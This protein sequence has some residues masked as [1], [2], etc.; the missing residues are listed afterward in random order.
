MSP[1]DRQ[2]IETS[3]LLEGAPRRIGTLLAERAAVDVL[4]PGA[5]LF[6][7]GEPPRALHLIL[8]GRMALIAQGAGEE[9]VIET[10]GEGEALLT[11]AVVL[12]RPY[13][14]GAKAILETRLATVPA[15][16]FR[17]LLERELALSRAVIRQLAW[18]WRMLIRQVKDLKLRAGAQR[19]AS[20]LL[21]LDRSRTGR[22]YLPME[23]RMLAGR[24]GMSAEHLSRAFARL[25]QY[26][27]AASGR[28]VTIADDAAL[29][30]FCDFD[31]L[32]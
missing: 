18:H 4:A 23:R 12:D 8:T 31:A 2:L 3:A 25:R 29:R 6:R 14:L 11:P 7:A 17:S 28:A 26:G 5:V 16:D 30:R 15:D 9:A 24:L 1:D 13:L 10:F 32:V 22:V 27:V 19:L 21:T 20:Y